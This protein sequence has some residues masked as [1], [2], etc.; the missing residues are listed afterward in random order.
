MFLSF[1]ADDADEVD[2]DDDDEVDVQEVE[3]RNNSLMQ[4]INFLF[5]PKVYPRRTAFTGICSFD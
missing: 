3:F 2:D 1:R 5:G 4:L